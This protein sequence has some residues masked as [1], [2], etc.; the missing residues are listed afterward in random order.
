M[1]WRTHLTVP[2]LIDIG[3]KVQLCLSA[4]EN[5]TKAGLKVRVVSMPSWELF[6]RQNDHYRDIVLPPDGTARVFAEQG[7]LLGCERWVD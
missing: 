1:S 2:V 5:M 7:T 4:P 6:D 3:C